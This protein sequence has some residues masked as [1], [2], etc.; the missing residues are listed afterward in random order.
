VDCGGSCDPC[1]VG[2]ICNV[3]EDCQSQVCTG[4]RC[5]AP[6]C[7]DGKVNQPWEQCD[8][9]PTGGDYCDEN[10]QWANCP[11]I[12]VGSTCVFVPSTQSAPDKP[13]ARS[14]CQNLGPGWG[15]CDQ[16]VVCDTAIHPYLISMCSCSGGAAT[17]ACSGTVNFYIHVEN[18]TDRSHYVRGPGFPGCTQSAAC[19]LAG[20]ATCGTPLC[21]LGP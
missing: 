13:T 9:G 16:S 19:A 21:C 5:A 4:G 15:L 3:D 20:T 17:C 10:C 14:I 18:G 11:G 6:I 7:G 1:A 12:M 2:K 8:E